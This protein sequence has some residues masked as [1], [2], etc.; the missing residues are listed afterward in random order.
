MEPWIDYTLHA[1]RDKPADQQQRLEIK[2]LSVK[3]SLML[4]W[5]HPQL[6]HAVIKDA[7]EDVKDDLSKFDPKYLI[8]LATL[9]LGSRNYRGFRRSQ[10]SLADKDAEQT[11]LQAFLNAKPA[12][13]IM[14]IWFNEVEQAIYLASK[15][16]EEEEK[17]SDTP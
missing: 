5:D 13:G 6:V 4:G 15:L 7:P 14:P 3:D 2:E 16:S 17:N 12:A 1:D 10:D 8:M 9:M 11:A